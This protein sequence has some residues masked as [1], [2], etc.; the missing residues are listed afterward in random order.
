MTTP[1]RYNVRWVERTFTTKHITESL[2]AP[3]RV[4]GNITD[5]DYDAATKFFPGF[6][7]HYRVRNFLFHHKYSC[8]IDL[9]S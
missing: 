6:H 1:L 7:R 4:S 5:R 3:E 9:S 8:L 2:L